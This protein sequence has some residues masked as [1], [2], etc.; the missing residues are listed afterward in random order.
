MHSMVSTPV[1]VRKGSWTEEEDNLLRKCIDKYGEGKWHQVPLRAGLN[2]CRKSCR[3]RWLN[4]LSPN[5][6]RGDFTPDEDDLII[7]LHNLLGNRWSLISGRLPGRTANDVKNH[8]NSHVQKKVLAQD[9]AT[10]KA[11]KT[12]KT[13]ILKPRPR[14]FK[15]IAPFSSRENI[16]FEPNISVTDQNLDTPSPSSSKPVDDE[17]SQWWS[18]LL[19][20]VKID[21]EPEPGSNAISLDK[22]I[23]ELFEF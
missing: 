6:K 1:E 14:T 18:N 5:I 19:D 12:T 13:T 8:W 4:Y 11:Q 7:R 10:R 21:G 15:R 16:T 2:R 17:C 3:L 20:S 23:W 9:E 22:D